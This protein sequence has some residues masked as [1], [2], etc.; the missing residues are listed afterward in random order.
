[1]MVARSRVSA[2]G[3]GLSVMAY[4]LVSGECDTKGSRHVMSGWGA[5]SK[6]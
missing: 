1:M 2:V 4:V 6:V 5:N 3:V